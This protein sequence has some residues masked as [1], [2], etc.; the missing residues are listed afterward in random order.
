MAGY[1]Q[2]LE[3]RHDEALSRAGGR[4]LYAY[5]YSFNGF[6]ARLTPE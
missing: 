6:A 5:R 3:A 4:K 1:A 2:Y